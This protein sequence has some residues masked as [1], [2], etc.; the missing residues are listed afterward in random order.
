MRAAIN[1]ARRIGMYPVF[2]IR[3]YA[4]TVTCRLVIFQPDVARSVTEEIEIRGE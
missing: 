3:L 1:P 4:D 2:R